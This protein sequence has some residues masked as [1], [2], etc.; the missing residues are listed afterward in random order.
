[1]MVDGRWVG[2]GMAL[3]TGNCFGICLDGLT[4]LAWASNI[5]HSGPT[6]AKRAHQ[7]LLFNRP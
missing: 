2:E 3:T 1:M 7:R 5:Y 4:S 6:F